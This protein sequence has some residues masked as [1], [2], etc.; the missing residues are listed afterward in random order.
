MNCEDYGT[1]CTTVANFMGNDGSLYVSTVFTS[2]ITFHSLCSQWI[3]YGI[4]GEITCEV[5]SS[6]AEKK[7]KTYVVNKRGRYYLKHNQLTDDIPI[8]IA[9]KG[10][11]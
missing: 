1:L 6:T 5:L 2:C 10:D 7:S 9:F 8:A 11:S 4:L 3:V